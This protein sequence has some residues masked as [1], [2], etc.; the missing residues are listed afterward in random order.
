MIKINYQLNRNKKFVDK[1]QQCF[2]FL[3]IKPKFKF[4][5]NAVKFI[6]WNVVNLSHLYLKKSILD[7]QEI[8][9]PKGQIISKRFFLA[10]DSSKIRTKTR[11]RLV[12]MNSFVRFLEEFTSWQFA[13]EFYWLLACSLCSSIVL[14]CLLIRIPTSKVIR[15]VRQALT[16]WYHLQ[17]H[18]FFFLRIF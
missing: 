13:F 6:P 18:T 4:A 12:K 7:I 5:V 8:V 9:S 11:R 17:D 15:I 16:E 2:S 3:H 14:L 10:E 1:A